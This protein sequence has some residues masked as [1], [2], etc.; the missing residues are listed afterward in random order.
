M[1]KVRQLTRQESEAGARKMIQQLKANAAEL[2]K[3]SQQDSAV[4]DV[5]QQLANLADS[6]LEWGE[7]EGKIMIVGAFTPNMFDFSTVEEDYFA[8]QD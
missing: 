1:G 6:L 5:C 2:E 8:S 4:R 7:H 3:R